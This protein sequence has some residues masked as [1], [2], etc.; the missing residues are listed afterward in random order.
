MEK[1]NIDSGIRKVET[2][3]SELWPTEVMLR[4]LPEMMELMALSW[5]TS[6]GSL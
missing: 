5:K 2:M 4:Q 1:A 6:W 3:G